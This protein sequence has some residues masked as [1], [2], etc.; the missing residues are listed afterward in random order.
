VL[1]PSITRA[2]NQSI[3][4]MRIS[5]KI[6]VSGF[7]AITIRREKSR[8]TLLARLGALGF[9]AVCILSGLMNWLID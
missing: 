1:E 2:L 5:I 7:R 9:L 3:T 4:E 8:F 6:P